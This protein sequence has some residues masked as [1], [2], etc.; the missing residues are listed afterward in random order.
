MFPR[1]AA[2]GSIS[3]TLWVLQYLNTSQWRRALSRHIPEMLLVEALMTVTVVKTPRSDWLTD[4]RYRGRSRDFDA[5][6]PQVPVHVRCSSRNSPCV[7]L[8][9]RFMYLKIF[10]HDYETLMKF[11]P[12]KLVAYGRLLQVSANFAR[13]L[14]VCHL[15]PPPLPHPPTHTDTFQLVPRCLQGFWRRS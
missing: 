14:P 13:N 1:S 10:M 4:N 5:R 11:C 3:Q 7:R 12:L 6:P 15:F 9:L 2:R 8:C